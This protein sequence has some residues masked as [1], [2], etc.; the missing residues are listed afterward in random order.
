MIGKASFS[1]VNCVT[2]VIMSSFDEA[3]HVTYKYHFVVR[4]KTFLSIQCLV[5]VFSMR[6]FLICLSGGSVEE[7][8][9]EE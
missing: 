4:E 3:Y 7:V 2:F 5:F 8:F 9:S 1:D 6:F